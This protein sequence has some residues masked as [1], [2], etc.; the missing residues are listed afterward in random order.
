MMCLRR[1]EQSGAGLVDVCKVKKGLEEYNF[2]SWL[3]PYIRQRQS[4]SNLQPIE[5]EYLC[6]ELPGRDIVNYSSDE[7]VCSQELDN[8]FN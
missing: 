1:A 4:F 3:E 8:F 5:G 7:S 2:M 6:E